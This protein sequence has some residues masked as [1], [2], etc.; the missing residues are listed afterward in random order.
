MDVFF[1][2]TYF[3][4]SAEALHKEKKSNYSFKCPKCHVHQKPD[5]H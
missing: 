2:N 5:A 4:S 3:F 1:K